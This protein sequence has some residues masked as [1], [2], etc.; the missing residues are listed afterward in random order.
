MKTVS[1]VLRFAWRPTYLPNGRRIF[2]RFYIE[3]VFP[4]AVH[5]YDYLETFDRGEPED[6]NQY[7][8]HPDLYKRMKEKT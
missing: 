2:L 3:K 8:D 1:Y 5:E 4:I 7:K 6:L